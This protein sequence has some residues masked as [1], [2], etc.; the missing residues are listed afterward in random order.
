MIAAIRREPVYLGTALSVTADGIVVWAGVSPTAQGLIHGI[1]LAW[2]AVVVRS[3]STPTVKADEALAAAK[4][5]GAAR[6]DTA[7]ANAQ[8]DVEVA[9]YVGAVEHQAT[10]AAATIIARTRPRPTAAAEAE[11]LSPSEG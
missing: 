6:L 4:A 7:V 9:K 3:L 11:K 8:T 2:V 10:T 5:D 1:V